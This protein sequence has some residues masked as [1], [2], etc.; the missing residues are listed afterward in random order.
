M[1][2][3][4]G[5]FE[6]LFEIGKGLKLRALILADPALGDLV[7]GDGIEV[8]KLFAA[9]PDDGDEVGVLEQVEVLGHGLTGHVEVRA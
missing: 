9:V 3:G 6:L 7:D 5:A 2:F 1:G 4:L 8:V